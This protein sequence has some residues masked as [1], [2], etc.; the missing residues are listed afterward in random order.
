MGSAPLQKHLLLACSV[1]LLCGLAAVAAALAPRAGAADPSELQGKLSGAR[2]DASTLSAE[3][4]QG[5]QRQLAAQ[6]EAEAAEAREAE[7]SSLLA[8]GRERTAALGREL[9]AAERRLDGERERLRRARRALATRLVAIY[10]QGVPDTA[11]LVVGSED[12]DQVA[13]RAEYLR[14][15]T[16]ADTALAAR[17]EAVRDAVRDDASAVATRRDRAVA[18]QRRLVAARSEISGVREA[19]Q[20]S[21]ARLGSLTASQEEK[22]TRLRADIDGWV[23]EIEV[24]RAASRAE[25]ESE[26]GRWLGGPYSIPTY[27]VICESGGNYGAL[28]PSSGAGGA[29]QILPST[30]DAY[31]GNGLP[32]QAPKDEQDRIAAQIWAD[33]GGSAWVCA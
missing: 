12:L 19:A 20:A 29:Y 21:A 23:R 30:W 28:N 31:G 4:R 13:A 15:V 25:A 33:S 27:I 10:K 9:E 8:D 5:K 3:L 24:A 11:E 22:L 32:H 26:V 17:V 1:A 18:H 2:Q 14:A 6:G 7:L 16:D